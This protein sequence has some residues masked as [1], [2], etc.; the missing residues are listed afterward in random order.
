ML[1]E[2]VGSALL[3]H[4]VGFG[5]DYELLFIAPED[6]RESVLAIASELKIK[7]TPIGETTE[8]TNV[9]LSGKTWPKGWHH[10]G[11]ER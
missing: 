6:A 4:Q 11:D 7:V 1:Q 9:V 5:E 3:T 2:L 8:S 10:F